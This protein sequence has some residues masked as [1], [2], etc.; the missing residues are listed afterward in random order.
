MGNL[1]NLVN[2]ARREKSPPTSNS[3]QTKK[4]RLKFYHCHRLDEVHVVQSTTS[5]TKTLVR[6]CFRYDLF[7]VAK[8]FPRT[9]VT[10]PVLPL[11][12][13]WRG[14]GLPQIIGDQR[15]REWWF[16]C[17]TQGNTRNPWIL[18]GWELRIEKRRAHK[19]N[20]SD[21]GFLG[22][23]MGHSSSWQVKLLC[24]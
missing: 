11:S 24:D 3:L 10:R 19:S 4:S 9:K 15:V 18:V 17:R 7:G 14:K 21:W 16:T 23:M 8:Y 5:K 12:S 6:R 1:R 20:V 22:Y 2:S 13:V